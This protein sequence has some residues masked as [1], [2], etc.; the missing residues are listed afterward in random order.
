MM[1]SEDI[2]ARIDWPAVLARLGVPETALRNKHGPCPA[3]GGKDRFRFDNRRHRGDFFCNNCGAGSGFDLLMRVHHWDFRT[4]RDQV[5]RAAGLDTPTRSSTVVTITPTV[6]TPEIAQPTLRVLRLWR[7]SC[8]VADCDDAVEYVVQRHLWPLPPNC[9]LKAHPSVDYFDDG[10]RI[11]RYAA[12]IARVVDIN[13]ELVAIHT[14]YLEHGRKLASH[15]PRKILS[16]LTG[17]TGCT[18]RLQQVDGDVL[19]IAEGIGLHW[20]LRI[21]TAFLRGQRSTPACS[22]SSSRPPRSSD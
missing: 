16:P 7:E 18:V 11:G 4:A 20:P 21:S 19:G 3:C 5:V 2:A 6:M 15:E 14:T 10:R 1:R 13:G 8:H 12:L 17:R 9:T 22:Q